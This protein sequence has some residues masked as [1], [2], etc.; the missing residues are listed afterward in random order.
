VHLKSSLLPIICF[1]ICNFLILIGNLDFNYASSDQNSLNQVTTDWLDIR[2]VLSDVG[3]FIIVGILSFIGVYIR[4]YFV[5]NSK[6]KTDREDF[7]KSQAYTNQSIANAVK[8]IVEDLKQYK[9]TNSKEI[10]EIR[11]DY[12]AVNNKVIQNEERINGLKEN[13]DYIRKNN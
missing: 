4:Q 13:I 9:E 7:E 1:I 2:S 3:V 12:K 8:L 11:S 10:D 6:W 5:N